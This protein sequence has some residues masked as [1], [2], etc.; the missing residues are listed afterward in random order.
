MCGVKKPELFTLRYRGIN[1]H[2]YYF[3]NYYKAPIVHQGISPKSKQLE[4]RIIQL[5]APRHRYNSSV[6][7]LA[8]PE[9]MV[10]RAPGRFGSSDL[11]SAGTLP[12]SRA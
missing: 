6:D 4:T 8:S 9:V 5:K 10:A 3:G 11:G 2:Q 1:R 12:R 7:C